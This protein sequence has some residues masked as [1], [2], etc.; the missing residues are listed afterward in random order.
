MLL[1]SIIQIKSNQLV[2]PHSSY[3]SSEENNG[4]DRPL[5]MAPSQSILTAFVGLG[6]RFPLLLVL[7]DM[8]FVVSTVSMP[9]VVAFQARVPIHHHQRLL[10][11]SRKYGSTAA[12]HSTS[13]V[14][15]IL[16]PSSFLSHVMLKVPSVDASVKYWTED[17]GGKIRVSRAAEDHESSGLLLKSAFV[18]LGCSPSKSKSNSDGTSEETTCFA[19]ELV[20]TNK[21]K[22]YSIGNAISYVGVS[23]LLQFENN[24]LG[25]ITG[26]DKPQQQADEPNGISVQSSASAPGDYLARFA[27]KSNKLQET[28]TFYTNILG[29]ECKAQDDT[30]LCLRYDNDCFS[31]GVPTTLVFD[32]TTDELRPGDCFD[33]LAITTRASIADIATELEDMDCKVFMKPT[34]MF[35]K[36]VMG[37]I[38]PNGYKV[39]LAGL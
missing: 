5:T 9:M 14:N 10:K 1:R 8:F 12:L 4:K 39:V 17:I 25:V 23:M 36:Q 7:F 3:S 18:E 38:D 2:V 30:M 35:G 11:Q 37:L 28:Y 32:A 31:S 6:R 19:L 13:S 21:D 16:G 29:M 20:Q 27:L 22:N 24:L 15:E 26:S 34:E 33:H